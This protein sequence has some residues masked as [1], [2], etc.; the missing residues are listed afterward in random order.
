M[1]IDRPDLLPPVPAGATRVALLGDI[2]GKTGRRAARAAVAPLRRAGV[3]FLA[4]NAENAS[5]GNGCA[6]REARDLLNAGFDALTMGNHVWKH[7]DLL[8][9]LEADLRVLRPLNFPPGTPGRGHASFDLPG[10]ARLLVVN[11]IGRTRLEPTACPFRTMDDLLAEAGGP[12]PDPPPDA[13]EPRPAVLVDFHA[14]ATA[15]KHALRWYLDGRVTAVLGT[16]THVQTSDAEVTPRGTG[17]VTDIGCC[18]AWPSVIGFDPQPV[19]AKYLTLRPHPYVPAEGPGRA[20]GAVLDL[21][22]TTGR[23]LAAWT[24]RMA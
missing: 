6:A 7:K 24:I 5:G 19:L 10:G 18:G 17:Y 14:D 13:T 20:E 4:A 16:H 15:E 9:L 3:A 1:T 8:P 12:G 21:D 23:C 11:L 22:P 2:V